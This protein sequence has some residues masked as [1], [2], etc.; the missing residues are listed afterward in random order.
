M[1]DVLRSIR[2]VVVINAFTNISTLTFL[3]AYHSKD[4]CIIDNRYQFYV[5]EIVEILYDLNSKAK[6]I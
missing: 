4:I 1:H 3:K 6:A 5:N 2:Y